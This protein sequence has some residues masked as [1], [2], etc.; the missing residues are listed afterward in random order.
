M[1]LILVVGLLGYSIYP[2]PEILHLDF[3]AFPGDHVL[4]HAIPGDVETDTLNLAVFR[5]FDDLHIPGCRLYLKVCRHRIV[6]SGCSGYH[7]LIFIFLAG[8]RPNE[9]SSGMVGRRH[10]AV[11]LNGNGFVDRLGRGNCQHI[12]IDFYRCSATDRHIEL[13][14]HMILIGQRKGIPAVGVVHLISFS[15]PRRKS[16]KTRTAVMSRHI[17]QDAV[18]V[19]LKI[20]VAAVL[21]GHCAGI[22]VYGIGLVVQFCR[23]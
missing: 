22:S 2:R 18:I 10:P 21:L 6:I 1:R 11:Q 17:R 16:G 20:F 19:I 8:N 23:R 3:T 4:V 13:V 14:Q 15:C 7:I 12:T 9:H 5:G